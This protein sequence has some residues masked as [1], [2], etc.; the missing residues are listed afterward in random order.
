MNSALLVC[1]PAH[2][3][4]DYE[5][6]PYMHT[7][8]QPDQDAATAEHASIVVAHLVAGRRVEYMIAAPECPDMVF[9]A[10]AALIRGDRA[11]LGYPP[12]ERKAE[13]PYFQEWLAGRDYDVIEASYPFSGQGDALV[14]GDLLLAGY[15]QRTDPRMHAVLARELSYDVVPLRTVSSRWYDLD[16]A[17]AVVDHSRTLAYCP[18]ALDDPSCQRL[19]GLG[20]DLIEVSVDEAARLA[21][22][23]I[24]DGTTVTM[25][26]G[27]P[28]LAAALRERGLHV[29]ELDTTEL[30]KGG[31]GIRSTALTLDN[32][33][34]GRPR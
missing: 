1:D 26:R 33:D 23:L 11:V 17:V 12:P 7:E 2:F 6:N 8:M 16:L 19:R 21:L 32:P 14:C 31:G 30:A 20:L 15:G 3:R 22:N 29:V 10:N 28:R 9:T 13:M 4:I 18:Q 27:A 25:S 34:P 5:I 24:S